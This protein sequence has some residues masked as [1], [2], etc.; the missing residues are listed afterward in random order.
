MDTSDRHSSAEE[1]DEPGGLTRSKVM[2]ATEARTHLGEVMRDVSENDTIIVVERN[3]SPTVAFVSLERL[4]RY[5][6]NP[7]P[8]TEHSG[9]A[10]ETQPGSAASGAR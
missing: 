7:N 1:R 2:S 6:Q 5:R 3:G 9:Q 10:S 8:P 4:A